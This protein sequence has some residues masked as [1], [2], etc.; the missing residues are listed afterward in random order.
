MQNHYFMSIYSTITSKIANIQMASECMHFSVEYVSQAL[1]QCAEMVGAPCQA[2]KWQC[3]PCN[4]YLSSHWFRQTIL[5]EKQCNQ[6]HFIHWF[7]LLSGNFTHQ[8]QVTN[9]SINHYKMVNS[10]E[11]KELPFYLTNNLMG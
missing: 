9:W 6:L 3:C 10:L 11:L 2:F 8:N 7:W 4:Y 1:M 5:L